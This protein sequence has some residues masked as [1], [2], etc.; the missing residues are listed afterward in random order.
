MQSTAVDILEVPSL[1]PAS[2]IN[3]EQRRKRKDST[4]SLDHKRPSR[5]E[6]RPSSNVPDTSQ[7]L[8]SGAKRKL[9]VR[10]DE[11]G[12]QNATNPAVSPDEF[13]FTRRIVE[14]K[15]PGQVQVVTENSTRKIQRDIAVARGVTRDKSGS[16]LSSAGRKAL[17]PKSANTDVANSP[18][19]QL[20]S[21]SSDEI[22]TAK[23]EVNKKG[24]SKDH[25][26]DKKQV[27]M[28][29]G[30][31]PEPPASSIEMQPEPE[32]PAAPDIFSPLSSGSSAIRAESRDTP[33]PPDLGP[34]TE[35]QRPSRRARGA[36]SY[37]EPNLRDKMRRPTKELVDAVTGEGKAHRTS[38]VKLETELPLTTVKIKQEQGDDDAWK[39]GLPSPQPSIYRN[40][41][42]VDK[43]GSRDSVPDVLKTERA[44]RGPYT[45]QGS[46]GE[47]PRSS[48]TSSISA[49]LAERRRIKQETKEKAEEASRPLEE[50]MAKLDIYEFN[51]SSPRE[52]TEK[53]TAGKEDKYVS[54]MSRR[55]SSATADLASV[56]SVK[57]SDLTSTQKSISSR[58]RQSVMADDNSEVECEE[59]ATSSVS[60]RRRQST[61]GLGQ[62]AIQTDQGHQ[63]PSDTSLKRSTSSTGLIDPLEVSSRSDRVSARRR[64]MML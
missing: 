26:R 51:G 12:Q 58:R 28:M 49:L 15:N 13:K 16:T 8:K 36:V 50:A 40:S 48:T 62:I 21:R 45:S 39:S 59:R 34:G 11:E 32:T 60:S 54:R 41:P 63:K 33:P 43:V 44:H 5:F 64:S 17:G 1:D 23:E 14:N 55:A 46:D 57:P 24:I 25:Q 4:V 38:F 30:S 10:D 7:S 20:K 9:S 22:A 42:L 53:V 18:K 29:I 27:P 37:A 61:L 47:L 2:S 35:G 56:V 52:A 19:K 3:L 6:P 31:E